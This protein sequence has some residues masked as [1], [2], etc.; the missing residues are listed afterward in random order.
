[1]S[2]HFYIFKTENENTYLYD[3]ITNSIH[4]W[5]L[6]VETTELLYKSENL[7]TFFEKYLDKIQLNGDFVTYIRL[8]RVRVG[9]FLAPKKRKSISISSIDEIPRQL[10]DKLLYSALILNVTE[11]C[12][13]RCN[14]CL[15]SSNYNNFRTHGD[16]F[17]SFE[18]AKKAINLFFK[19]N[20]EE[21]FKSYTD[22]ALNIA[23]YGGE[24]L[25]NFDLIKK[26]VEY[27]N[28][29][30]RAHY[31]LIIGLSTNLT[32]LK[33]EFIPFLQQNKI[34]VNVSLDGP[35]KTHN[36]HRHFAD[37][38]PTYNKVLENLLKIKKF[39]SAYYETYIKVLPT[40]HGHSDIEE[41]Y[42]FFDK[43]KDLF[44]I[45]FVSFLRDFTTCNF[46]KVFPYDKDRFKDAFNKIKKIYSQNKISNV[47]PLKGEFLYFVLEDLL[48]RLFHSPQFISSQQNWYTGTCV[49]TKKLFVTPNGK[50]H[51]C[52]RICDGFSIGDVNNGVDDNKIVSI[53]NNYFASIP[54]CANCWARNFCSLC[55]A[56][57]AEYG[58]FNFESR[59][60]TTKIELE[61]A[62]K[63]LYSILEENPDAFDVKEN[64][65]SALSEIF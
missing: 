16:E 22:R 29:N 3:A 4:I 20:D 60:E 12:N 1:M 44:N 28:A 64:K 41:L 14:Y 57:V 24:P 9:A 38:K 31:D 56:A 27:A 52:E 35:K 34:F 62:F 48:S 53:I 43:N 17:M 37:G 26:C 2:N 65:R 30:K 8:W 46:H 40:I 39:D 49:P 5:P 15:Y 58:K 33:D 61:R 25:L 54:D 21:I 10:K 11:S 18:T 32:L 59:C 51:I 19:K 55:I 42:Y 50:I 45:Q 7:E 13:L 47:T 36:K 63:L 6:N 23:F